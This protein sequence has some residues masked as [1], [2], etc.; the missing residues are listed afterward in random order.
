MRIGDMLRAGW[1]DEVRELDSS[2]G[3]DAPA[4]NATGYAIM[5]EHVR[6]CVP[7]DDAIERVAIRTRQYAKRQ[8]T[9]FRH[10]LPAD[11]VTKLDPRTPDAY[12]IAIA[13]WEAAA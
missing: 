9:W 11:V 3:W 7:L 6:C 10:Q 13:W 8:R 12:K 1:L 2:V 5:R 4:W